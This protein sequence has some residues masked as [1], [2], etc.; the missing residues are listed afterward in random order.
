MKRKELLR[1]ATSIY[2]YIYISV[3]EPLRKTENSHLYVVYGREE[4]SIIQRNVNT[5]SFAI[6]P[7][8]T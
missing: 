2:I 4:Y 6:F 5:A 1:K 8:Y 7:Q 3:S